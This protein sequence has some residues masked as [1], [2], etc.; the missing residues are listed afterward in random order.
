M[1]LGILPDVPRGGKRENAG[2]PLKMEDGKAVS[3]R[4]S[5]QHRAWIESKGKKGH[6]AVREAI[7]A[8]IEREEDSPSQPRPEES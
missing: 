3:I 7:Q 1:T 4:L 8:A 2:A 5:K 6:D